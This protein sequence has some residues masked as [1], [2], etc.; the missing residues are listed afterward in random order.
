MPSTICR[1]LTDKIH[2]KNLWFFS[3]NNSKNDQIFFKEGA[4][5]KVAFFMVNCGNVSTLHSY[6]SW[7]VACL[8]RLTIRR[9]F[10][11]ALARFE[12]GP[13]GSV[14]FSG[15]FP[16]FRE[17]RSTEKN[18]TSW[19]PNGKERDSK[20]RKKSLNGKYMIRKKSLSILPPP[21]KY[22]WG[23]HKNRTE[24]DAERK[25]KTE[26]EKLAKR[27]CDTVLSRYVESLFAFIRE[28][29]P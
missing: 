7:Q 23:K 19:K 6:F 11:P 14:P 21:W 3:H 24:N 29:Y 20:N 10:R 5:S 16:F 26:G 28:L 17:K 2:L 27:W 1:F 8:W 22:F 18:G 13:T 12:N 25:G 15:F 9:Q 4:T